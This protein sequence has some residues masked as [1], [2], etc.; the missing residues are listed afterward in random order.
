MK[1]AAV[2]AALLA[3]VLS[4][5]RDDSGK[6][7]TEGE[8]ETFRR[9]SDDR[10]LRMVES[11]DSTKVAVVAVF[12][13]DAFLGYG[14]AIEESGIPVLNEFGNA[15]LLLASAPQIRQMAS[16]PRLRRITYF[17]A[18]GRLG[19]LD[20]VLELSLLR[21]AGDGTED[22]P[23]EAVVRFGRMP[24]EKERKAIGDAGLSVRSGEGPAWVVA[25][26]ARAIP[27]ILDMDGVIYI[28]STMK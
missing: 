5:C 23:L 24:G 13:G 9:K 15:A 28:E 22:K 1:R 19:R 26:P 11:G 7:M 4:G 17:S 16:S 25:G 14:Q 8:R 21:H 18:H 12:E 3:L 10:L 27:R 6:P 20:P 2:L